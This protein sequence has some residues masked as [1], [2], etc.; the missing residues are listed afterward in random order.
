MN[1]CAALVGA[2]GSEADP[3]APRFT[4]TGGLRATPL[5]DL[6]ISADLRYESTRFAD[7]QNTLSLSPAATVDAR[8]FDWLCGQVEELLRSAG[9]QP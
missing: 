1:N 9:A 7:D 4:L 5:D 2:T 3:Q 6:T 8:G